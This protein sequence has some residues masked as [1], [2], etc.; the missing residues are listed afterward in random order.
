MDPSQQHLRLAEVVAALSIA[1]DL[2]TGHP[3]ERALR[4]CLFALHLGEAMQCDE[5][6]LADVY[7]VT[8]LRFA[9]C[10]ADARHRAALFGDEIALGPEI[11][12]VELWQIEPMVAFLQK[13]GLNRLP[14]DELQTLMHT[15]VQRSVEAAIANCEVGQSIASRLG[16]GQ[17]VIR[18]LGDVFERWDGGGVPGTAS[19]SPSRAYRNA[20]HGCRALFSP[21]R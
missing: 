19:D 21:R 6:T 5:A 16:L 7:Y 1:T 18:G 13:Q 9:G 11:D 2:G 20:G 10:A 17:G 4:A 8:L 14:P 3:M 12:T 15:G